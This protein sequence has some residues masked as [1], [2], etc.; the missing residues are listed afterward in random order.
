MAAATG[1]AWEAVMPSLTEGVGNDVKEAVW[2]LAVRPHTGDDST[3][4]CEREVGS[5]GLPPGFRTATTS[6]TPVR[7]TGRVG[8]CTMGDLTS[9]GGERTR[10]KLPPSAPPLAREAPALAAR[11]PPRLVELAEG[12]GWRA[13]IWGEAADSCGGCPAP[14]ACGHLTRL[15]R[16]RCN[17]G[18]PMA[19]MFRLPMSRVMRASVLSSTLSRRRCFDSSGNSAGVVAPDTLS[20]DCCPASSEV[21]PP[22][23]A[24]ATRDGAAAGSPWTARAATA[25]AG[26]G[27]C[28]RVDAADCAAPTEALSARSSRS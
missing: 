21:D 18:D 24:S 23:R 15:S 22:C 19:R 11:L 6:P 10:R 13:N 9:A 3:S 4:T 17:R 16:L 26:A 12:S 7:V 20:T 25:G 27:E 14:R 5:P 28:T 1:D 8:D 2:L